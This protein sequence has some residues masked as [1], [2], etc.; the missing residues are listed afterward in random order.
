MDLTTSAVLTHANGSATITASFERPEAQGLTIEAPGLSVEF[1]GQ[2]FTTWREP[3]VL[4][5]VQ[6]GDA[7]EEEF[8]ACDPYQL[9]VEAVS[10]RIR[11]EDAWVL[12]LDT[13]AGG[14]RRRS[15]PSPRPP[16]RR[17]ET[18]RRPLSWHD[19]PRSV[20]AHLKRPPCAADGSTMVVATTPQRRVPAFWVM[21]LCVG[22][23][24]VAAY[25]FLVP[26]QLVDPVGVVIGVFGVLSIVVGVHLWRPESR[27][28]WYLLAAGVAFYVLGD[29]IYMKLTEQYGSE[30]P[31]PSVADIAY[32][33][34]YPLLG[35]SLFL[36]LRRQMP[37]RDR[38]GTRRRCTHHGRGRRPLVDLPDGPLRQRP[39]P[40]DCP[41]SSPRSGT[42]SVTCC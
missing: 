3:C 18:S 38:A 23:A 36:T 2:A 14:R 6:D 28:P 20:L 27:A 42:P 37:G 17:D 31:F 33:A 25:Y 19:R 10:A 41:R 30:P 7:R 26:E 39:H 24:A 5:V 29:F 9:M 4:R 32:Y 15:T 34:L 35:A 12:P 8:A 40:A 1:G 13:S 21:Q 22:M 11:G 16:P